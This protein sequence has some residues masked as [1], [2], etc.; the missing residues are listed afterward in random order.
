MCSAVSKVQKPPSVVPLYLHHRSA[1]PS[2]VI[3][4]LSCFCGL[5]HCAC[6]SHS[7]LNPSVVTPC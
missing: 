6:G 7:D 2:S 5:F 4:A 1:L 3:E